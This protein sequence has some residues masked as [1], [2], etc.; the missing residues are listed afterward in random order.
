MEHGSDGSCARGWLLAH[1]ASL[2]ACPEPKKC[3]VS[4][5]GGRILLNVYGSLGNRTLYCHGF[6]I[7][8]ESIHSIA[9]VE[10]QQERIAQRG[11]TTSLLY[12][13]LC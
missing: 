10:E 4:H 12:S 13:V 2:G 11:S 8:M 3:F 5:G 1:R 9:F 6:G 7:W